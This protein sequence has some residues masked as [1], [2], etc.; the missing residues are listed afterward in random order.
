M[1]DNARRRPLLIHKDTG[2]P[3][4][5]FLDATISRDIKEYWTDRIDRYGG[6]VVNKDHNAEI[7]LISKTADRR[8][9][10]LAYAA[11]PDARKRN[12]SVQYL[13]FL[14]QCIR[15]RMF[16][17]PEER[18]KGMSGQI[19][20][21]KRTDYTQED[22]ENLA[23]Y[24]AAA[25][26]ERVSGGRLG[27][28]PYIAL[29]ALGET[30]KDYEW[31]N[32]HTWQSWRN[33]Y[34]QK[35]EKIDKLIASFVP[36]MNPKRMNRWGED[37]RVNKVYVKEEQEDDEDEDRDNE[38]EPEQEEG[39]VNAKRGNRS[40]SDRSRSPPRSGKRR[41]S[42]GSSHRDDRQDSAGEGDEHE[43]GRG[44]S[45]AGEPRSPPASDH[46]RRSA[47]QDD[48]DHQYNAGA[49]D[50]P[51]N[52]AAGLPT[53]QRRARFATS[54]PKNAQSV[55][56][57]SP[58]D[59]R[60]RRYS[61]EATPQK[62][63]RPNP[64]G[65]SGGGPKVAK[66]SVRVAAGGFPEANTGS[67]EEEDGS[68]S[69]VD[70]S[71]SLFSEDDSQADEGPTFFDDGQ[72]PASRT[73][74]TTSEHH[75]SH[76]KTLVNSA[77]SFF[78]GQQQLDQKLS[79]TRL[80]SVSGA[81]VAQEE[82]QQEYEVE[83]KEEIKV[84]RMEVEL[85]DVSME[86]PEHIEEEEEAAE[87]VLPK[88]ELS[89][90]P[91]EEPIAQTARKRRRRTEQTQKAERV[92][93]YRMTRS[94]SRSVEPEFASLPLQGSSRRKGKGKARVV[95][96]EEVIEE[97][98]LF[99]E[100]EEDD[101]FMQPAEPQPETLADEEDVVNLV[102]NIS[103]ATSAGLESSATL[104]RHES[105]SH[106]DDAQ[107]L[108]RMAAQHYER[109]DPVVRKGPRQSD[110]LLQTFNDQMK[111]NARPRPSLPNPM[112]LTMTAKKLQAEP[113]RAVRASSHQRASTSASAPGKRPWKAPQTP[114]PVIN[115]GPPSRMRAVSAAS[116]SNETTESIPVAGT[117]AEAYK[118]RLE[119]EQKHTPYTPP[120]GTRAS[121]YLQQQ[122]EV[123]RSRRQR[124]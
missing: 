7:V 59:L 79:T 64:A 11:N 34:K 66:R 122:Q 70:V 117:R 37:R 17:I 115:M 88:P 20:V 65:P 76:E 72:D 107:T 108:E 123:R 73:T 39:G 85:V 43:R 77:P 81:N 47:E 58:P 104:S 124:T 55:E 68:T 50:N 31:A 120:S 111:R 92:L 29:C 30:D 52:P 57:K 14:E 101:D 12:I 3:V 36:T 5:F 16:G 46:G 27:N 61:F 98:E 38:N 80:S 86:E 21:R 94:R 75:I 2:T 56:P 93:P 15:D 99:L 10:Q 8:K 26:P 110:A 53:P 96:P 102:T 24:I 4:K 83:V 54:S 89:D 25:L 113:S 32:R 18:L 45:P 121:M 48:W 69:D 78:K 109:A 100:D 60:G 103:N 112:M 42:S 22:D 71:H 105:D 62:Q 97:E 6:E 13:A 44:G 91:V 51:G 67:E 1:P 63:P 114:T 95:E 28:N 74:A 23:R 9:R 118:R 82:V 87:P 106:S 116:S 40:D 41:R 19:G 84:E 90:D 35:P 49:F 33:R 119:E